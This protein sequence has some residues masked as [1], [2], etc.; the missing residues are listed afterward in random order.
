MSPFIVEATDEVL[1]GSVNNFCSSSLLSHDVAKKN[2]NFFVSE[3]Q[4]VYLMR[5]WFRSWSCKDVVLIQK[6]H[7]LDYKLI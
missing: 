4:P 2:W 1:R 5:N 3:R 6:S 7:V